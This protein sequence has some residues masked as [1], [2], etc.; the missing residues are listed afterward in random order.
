[1]LPA[2]EFCL[3]TDNGKRVR[4][5]AEAGRRAIPRRGWAATGIAVAVRL[6]M[7]LLLVG[8]VA[9]A[10]QSS[11]QKTETQKESG[12][13]KEKAIRCPSKNFSR[14][15]DLFSDNANLQ[16]RF[17]R[18]PLEYWEVIDPGY[19]EPSREYAQ[20]TIE[21]FEMIPLLDRRDGGRIFP[22][23]TKRNRDDL[24]IVREKGMHENPEFP[25]ERDA[26]DDQVVELFTGGTG[27]GIY[28]RFALSG[29]C[30]FLEAIH[31][32]SHWS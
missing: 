23:R 30:W 3:S 2:G 9:A 10:P 14:F 8:S 5:I 31:D 22:S 29:D 15:L 1:M 6:I 27:F 7:L 18:M 20:R 21:S 17:T 19:A 13:Q 32:K 12:A 28:F 11:K 26:P 16:R 24:V 25:E 4:T